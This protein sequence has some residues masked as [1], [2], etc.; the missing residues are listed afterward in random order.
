M[1]AYLSEAVAPGMVHGERGWW[2]PEREGKDP[3]LF[4]IFESN[5][6]VLVDDDP[7]NAIPAP[8]A[9]IPELSDV[10]SI[11][12]RCRQM[13]RPIMV[14]DL[15]KCVGCY[16]CTVACQI[17]HDLPPLELWNKVYFM[18][19]L[20]SILTLHLIIFRACMHCAEPLVSMPVLREQVI[21]T[22]RDL[23]W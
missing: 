23:C 20:V 4:G 8:A 2:Y 6:N 11:R 7:E 18:G 14:I 13:S 12:R 10:K 21:L 3:E 17:E 9:G 15:T 16:A 22:K 1:R 19:R 5:V